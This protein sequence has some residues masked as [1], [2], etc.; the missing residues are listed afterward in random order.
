MAEKNYN[1]KDRPVRED[2]VP[3]NMIL[4]MLPW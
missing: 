4:R 1:V 3:E 2:Y